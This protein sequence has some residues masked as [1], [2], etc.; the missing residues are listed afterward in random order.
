MTMDDVRNMLRI[1]VGHN[2][3]AWARSR[4]VSPQYVNDILAGRR[5]PG[6]SVLEALGV[7]RVT[8]YQIKTRA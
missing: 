8:T 5:P 2:R 4:G 1:V 7:E 6:D 3:A